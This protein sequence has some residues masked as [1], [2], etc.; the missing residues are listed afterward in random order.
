MS[1]RRRY[2]VLLTGACLLLGLPQPARGQDVGPTAPGQPPPAAAP[3]LGGLVYP[4]LFGP[5]RPPTRW[6]AD[7]EL[8]VLVTGA[9]HID[10]EV[11]AVE[12]NNPVFVSPRVYVGRRLE[13]GAAVRLTYRNLTQV[14]RLG[15]VDE[16]D[17]DY[18]S[19][20]SFTANWLDLD[21]VTREY[22]LFDW[23]RVQAEA[24][25]R[26]A[27]RRIG[28]WRRSPSDRTDSA[29]NYFGGGPHLGLTSHLLL[30]RSGWAVYS[31]ADVAI[32]FGGTVTTY[33]RRPEQPDPYGWD[34]AESNRA[35]A[36]AYQFDLGLQLGLA[37]RGEWRG[38]AVGFVA[39][40]QMDV[41]TAGPLGG[42]FSAAGLVNAGPFMRF[43]L[44]F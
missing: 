13:S 32:T 30:G 16:P 40:V 6:Y 43:E 31:R 29:E 15:R 19:G 9:V 28:S 41:L 27:H 34:V 21:F 24:G 18:R 42:E 25:G 12:K 2:S 17:G 1:P 10:R 20:E 33:N 3:D 26:F 23:W 4:E 7:A 14:G 37:R 22:A 11:G 39:G 8:A 5:A 35:T 38:R 44:G 36:G